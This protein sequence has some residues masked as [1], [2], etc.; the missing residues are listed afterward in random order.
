MRIMR[1]V[2]VIPND[3]SNETNGDAEPSIAVNLRNPNEMVITAFTPPDSG[4]T[5]GPL[6]YSSDRGENWVLRFDIPGGETHDQSPAWPSNEFYMGTLRGDTG[7]LNVVRSTDPSTGT[8]FPVLDPR[9]PVD[10]PWVEA[11]TVVGGPDDGK[12]RLYVGY[13]DSGARSAT[14]D[15]CL[16]AQAAVPTFNQVRLD[17]RS[18]SPNDGYEIRPTAHNDGT[19]YIAYKSRHSFV[20]GNSITDIVVARDDNWG[21]GGSPFTDLIDP[22]GNAGKLV[23][24]NVP[25]NEVTNIGGIRLNNDLNIAVD[26][27]NSDVVY[28]VWCD[29]SGPNYTLRVRRSLHRGVDWSS[30]L[31]TADNA[32]MACLTINT[33][34]TIGLFYQQ[35]AAG[36][37]ETH[38][39]SSNDGDI[40][41]DV[42]LARTAPSPNFTGDY[43]RLVAVGPHFY[44]VF[45][46]MN[47]P[48]PAN[49]FP[50]GGG[51][52]RFQRNT[53]GTSLRG[54]DGTSVI[55]VS[56]DPFFFK[57]EE[58]NISFIIER[59]TLGQDEIDARRT[60]PI[61]TAGGLPVPDAFRV[62]V[63]GF[64]A[65]ELGVTGANS[66]LPT[67][68]AASPA[69][70]ITI[71]PAG[72]TS[73][74]GDYG[75]EIQRFT[76]T[77][78]IDFDPDNSAFGFITDTEF[79]TLNITVAGIS[80]SA[81]I[82]L[83]K[84]PNPFILHGDPAWLSIDLRV[85]VVRA[86]QI[87]FG[88]TM[89]SDASAAPAF[90]QSVM[91]NLTA[92]HGTAGGE[93]FDGLSTDEAASSLYI[94]PTDGP[95]SSGDRVFNFALA[96]VHY[97]GLIGA[98]NVRVF[99]RL[100]NAQTT[101]GAFDP[102][103]TYRRASANPHGHPIALPGIQGDEYVT[104]PCFATSRIDSTT[105]AM[106]QQTDDPYNVQT[107]AAIGGAE[108][109]H[110]FGCWLD[111]NQ[112]FKPDGTTP[113]NVLPVTV[114]ASNVNGPFTDS[115][116]PP[117]SIQQAIL[118]N[119]HQCLIAEIAFDPVA[120]PIGKDPSNWDKLAQ[121][122][123]A[124]SD[125]GSAQ[126]V[127]TFEIRP[128]PMGL[129]PEETPDELMIDWGNTPRGSLAEIYLP[130]VNIS[131][132][133]AMAS[134]MYTSH[135]LVST[136]DH[137]L[138]IRTGGITYVPIP[139]G[140]SINY[141]GL[142]SVE[143][144]DIVRRGQVYSIVVRQVTNAFAKG[145]TPPP[146]FKLRRIIRSTTFS[147]IKWRRVL[148][149]FQLNIPV[150][151]KKVLL[152][153]EERQ[154]S[155][156]RWIAEAISHHN[157]WYPVFRRYLDYIAGRVK[158]FGGDPTQILPSPTGEGRQKHPH[159]KEHEEEELM[160][161]T[162]KI[163]GLIFDRFGDFEGFILDTEDGHRKFFSREKAMEELAERTWRERFRIT[164]RAER[165]EPHRPMSITVHQPPA[166]FQT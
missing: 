143:L 28:I 154:L 146:Q 137:T 115:S 65:T 165:D 101:S 160:A 149:A 161:F 77:Y 130:A 88:V 63:D 55:G 117:L 52:F 13:N 131:D 11:V 116:N 163:S 119:L 113:N 94:Y 120:I 111:I 66:T 87:K 162:G 80:A 124:W 58:R 112:P 150:K 157:R 35:L 50:N 136:D 18:P 26:P 118:R 107:F 9:S 103:S 99:F 144:P 57:I 16:D 126:A 46:A 109:D 42:L 22:D 106:D 53:S 83:I 95:I 7:E 135:R 23:A 15:I 33:Q 14:V 19:V 72:N 51:T 141:A 60:L 129:P 5:E 17:P 74:Y 32:S 40:W 121:R 71:I 49:F 29:N 64:T 76:F 48:D 114:P 8:P 156:L 10:Q 70:G 12:Q 105:V 132:V 25:I 3:H 108:V 27:T 6:F 89:G 2:N 142:L 147:D 20:G 59:S 73:D 43:A 62:V 61:N 31:L 158:D 145:S 78:K 84:Q 44:G 41:D 152:V 125:I 155:V 164:V 21:G 90:I 166:P 127:D 36:Q 104:I 159:V 68:P 30:D 39:R 97:I 138:Q 47:T 93:T 75:P 1:I 122:N 92:G 96:K 85:F 34:G 139:P 123:L 45:A 153:Q 148:G 151:E 98:T 38:F 69:T 100:F 56:V 140:F 67:L 37:M 134:K 133:L 110:F 82:E 102:L 79:V 86:G 128:T 24:T 81:Q 4:V 91:A 54:I